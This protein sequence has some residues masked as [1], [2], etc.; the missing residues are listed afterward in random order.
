M[1]KRHEQILLQRIYMNDYKYA[2]RCSMTLAFK[3]TQIKIVISNVI[4][5][6]IRITF[7][8]TGNSAD[9]NAEQLKLIIFWVE[10]QNRTVTLW[11]QIVS[12][13]VTYTYYIIQ[14]FYS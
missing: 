11:K 2:W 1:G 3:E 5:T 14:Q 10:I 4:W 8:E 6:Q 9:E 12:Y 7:L 13:K